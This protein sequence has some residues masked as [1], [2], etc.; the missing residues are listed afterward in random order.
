M[1]VRRFV[2]FAIYA[3]FLAAA[4]YLAFSAALV[5]LATRPESRKPFEAFPADL[6]LQY[7]DVAFTPR[8]E[9]LQLRGWFLPGA[10]GA[11]HLVFVHGIDSQRTASKALELAARLVRDSG[12][13]VLLFDLRAHGASDGDL[14]TAGDRER[15][16]V[17]GAYDFV[18]SRGAQP[19][20]VG[21]LGRSYGAGIAIMAAAMEPGIAAVIADS[22][23][24]SVEA[25]A[26]REVA[27]RTPFPEWA[28]PVFKPAARVFADLLYDIDL[29]SLSP[30]HD[31]AGLAYPVLVIHGQDDSRTP[32]SQGRRVYEAA[33]RGSEL[34]APAGVE[35]TQAF[36]D[37][38]DEYLRRA[39]AYLAAR[40][41]Q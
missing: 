8:G 6:G 37:F 26:A 34:W 30:E 23:F 12:Y 25:K 18:V 29:G 24:S 33:P 20:R 9:D 11:P 15:Y 4:L 3:G 35:H 41:G 40:L 32:L 2:S 10:P 5:Y 28:V 14:V 7:E 38:P 16:D 1:A 39:T 17:L 22:T 27:L 36:A 19:G 13:N 21:V 31:V